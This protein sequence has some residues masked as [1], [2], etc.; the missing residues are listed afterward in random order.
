MKAFIAA[1]LLFSLLLLLI[2]CNVLYINKVES[3]MNDLL[4]ALPDWNSP[5][6]LSA[7]V[8]LRD[9]WEH[10]RPFV[11]LSTRYSLT[12]RVSEHAATLV[13]C[14]ECGDLFGYQTALALLTDAIGDVSRTEQLSS[15][16]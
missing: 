7:A 9:H 2:L 12:D 11:G 4:A 13:A 6:R 16:W 15:V 3:D 1:S 5:D 14:A 10:H 8:A